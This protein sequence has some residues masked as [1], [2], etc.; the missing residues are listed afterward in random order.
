MSEHT[1]H[2]HYRRH[3]RWTPPSHGRLT[4]RRDK[5][6]IIA[7]IVGV[8]GSVTYFSTVGRSF[9]VDM[10]YTVKALLTP[11]SHY[12]E[13]EVDVLKT[14]Y[15]VA[16]ER[17]AMGDSVART[18]NVDSLKRDIRRKTIPVYRPPQKKDTWYISSK[19]MNDLRRGHED[20][21]KE[22]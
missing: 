21:A 14:N 16:A 11:D 3:S 17:E 10:V 18:Q 9:L 1:H 2:R 22:D 8:V 5:K 4:W 7:L 13:M 12:Q 20:K 15:Q 19:D 6:V